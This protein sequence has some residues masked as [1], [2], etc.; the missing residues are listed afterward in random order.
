MN[1][2]LPLIVQMP[3]QL[4]AFVVVFE[5]TDNRSMDGLKRSRKFAPKSWIAGYDVIFNLINMISMLCRE[6]SMVNIILQWQVEVFIYVHMGSLE[7]DPT[8]F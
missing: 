4:F 2:S 1:N 7:V 5:I 8:N 3:W 6:W